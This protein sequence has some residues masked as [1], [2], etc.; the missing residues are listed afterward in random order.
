MDGF[1]SL[2]K[3]Q[4]LSG[5]IVGVI[6]GWDTTTGGSRPDSAGTHGAGS[7]R[8]PVDV[9]W[10]PGGSMSHARWGWRGS[11]TVRWRGSATVGLI[12]H[13]ALGPSLV[14]HGRLGMSLQPRPSIVTHIL[15]AISRTGPDGPRLGLAVIPRCPAHHSVRCL[16]LFFFGS[17]I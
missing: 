1:P 14:H 5:H 3:I 4:D 8:M 15:P 13:A 17:W 9:L 11:A 2:S 7:N 6:L 12:A 10:N 16:L